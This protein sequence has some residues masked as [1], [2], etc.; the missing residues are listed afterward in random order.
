[1]TRDSIAYRPALPGL[2]GLDPPALP[3][4][5]EGLGT[6]LAGISGGHLANG[7]APGRA[8]P[9]KASR[10]VAEDGVPQRVREYGVRVK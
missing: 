10:S 4:G 8:S 7:V 9:S 1:M 6:Q 2:E 5:L 3:P